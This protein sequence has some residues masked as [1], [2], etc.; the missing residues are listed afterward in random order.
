MNFLSY[1][2]SKLKLK[3]KQI[4]PQDNTLDLDTLELLSRQKY[5]KGH[6]REGLDPSIKPY[7]DPYET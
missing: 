2:L 4:L 6:V 1:Q 3:K 7:D 5:A